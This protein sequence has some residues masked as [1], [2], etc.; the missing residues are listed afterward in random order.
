MIP[1]LRRRGSPTFFWGEV[2][3]T[4]RSLCQRC[5]C[6]GAQ[7]GPLRQWSAPA[8]CAGRMLRVSLPQS[9]VLDLLSTSYERVCWLQR[10]PQTWL[11]CAPCAVVPPQRGWRHL[12][13]KSGCRVAGPEAVPGTPWFSKHARLTCPDMDVDLRGREPGHASMITVALPGVIG[14]HGGAVVRSSAHRQ[15][16]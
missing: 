3:W 5:V 10:G 7:F 4:A 12:P 16:F 6:A 9:P 13:S 2:P 8:L 15:S 11:R 14:A 1:L